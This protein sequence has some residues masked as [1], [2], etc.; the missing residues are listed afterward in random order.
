MDKYIV[1]KNIGSGAFGKVWLAKKKSNDDLVAIKVMNKTAGNV[2]SFTREVQTLKKLGHECP[3]V[4][5]MQEYFTDEKYFY[6]VMDYVAGSILN[7][8]TFPKDKWIYLAKTLIDTVRCIHRMGITH[9]DIKPENIMIAENNEIK[10]L[11]F[12][13]G[14]IA[15]DLCATGG[16]PYFLSPEKVVYLDVYK[17]Y[18]M[19]FKDS[20][21]SDIW[22][23][24]TVLYIMAY[25]QRPYKALN[26][27]ELYDKIRET[28]PIFLAGDE[29]EKKHYT[30]YGHILGMLFDRDIDRR[31]K[32]FNTIDIS[33]FDTK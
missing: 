28:D 18:K 10:L 1:I 14:C 7:G 26:M 27:G 31:I 25:G 30:I 8:L 23:L 20:V 13:L 11:D 24:A 9:G 16:S 6:I 3:Y 5:H 12:G 33:V 19:P 15:D 17:M 2:Q 4:V 22:A 29:K 21:A 32:N